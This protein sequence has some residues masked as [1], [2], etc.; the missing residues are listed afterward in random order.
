MRCAAVWHTMRT[1]IAAADAPSTPIAMPASAAPSSVVCK[2]RPIT[3][4]SAMLH[5]RATHWNA[6]SATMNLTAPGTI[7]SKRLSNTS[8]P[9]SLV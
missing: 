7:E 4:N 6:T 9:F 8:S 5:A 2:N 3:M 1:T